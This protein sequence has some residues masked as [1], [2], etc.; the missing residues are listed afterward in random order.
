[1]DDGH[2]LE[3]VK[4]DRGDDIPSRRQHLLEGTS[5]LEEIK[6]MKKLRHFGAGAALG[7]SLVLAAAAPAQAQL[8]NGNFASGLNHW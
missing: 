6:S 2:P 7:V 1:V 5:Y 8:L 3:K 4:S